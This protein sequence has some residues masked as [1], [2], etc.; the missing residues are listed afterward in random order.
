MSNSPSKDEQ[1][2]ASWRRNAA[3]WSKA[4]REQQIDSRRLVTDQ[5][6]ID[7]VVSCQ[8]QTVLDLGCGEGW[9]V[10]RLLAAGIEAQGVDAVAELLER[11][12]H[13]GVGEYRQ[14]SYEQLADSHIDS[15]VDAVVCN[16]SLLGEVA[17]EQVFAAMPRLLKP[18]GVL[19]VQTLHPREAC[20][21]FDY[22]DGWRP[23]T[24]QGFS[25]DFAQPA[26]WYFRTLES[27]QSLF[28]RYG[29][30]DIQF[31]EPLYPE[32]GKPASV[33]FTAHLAVFN[34]S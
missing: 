25:S 18:E 2:L 1:I 3:P 14:L 19:I 28:S 12:R 10:R 34:R 31:Q 22:Q 23:G 11:A 8:P 15:P 21:E 27:W 13:S 20:G 17:V 30:D 33:I 29:F 6:I 7:A 9:L 4:V 26:P 16:F 32:S 5:A 24:W